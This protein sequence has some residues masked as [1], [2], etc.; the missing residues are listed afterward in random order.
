VDIGRLRL[1]ANLPPGLQGLAGAIRRD[2]GLYNVLS[3]AGFVQF[4]K[5]RDMDYDPVCFDLGTRLSDGDC[6]IVKFD[7]EE[8]LCNQRLVE[9]AELAP[10]F[11]QLIDI[12]IEDANRERAIEALRGAEL[13]KAAGHLRELGRDALSVL[14]AAFGRE[15]DVALRRR[16]VHTAWQGG[17]FE[18]IPFLAVALNDN[19]PTVWKEA[20]DGL[21]ALGAPDAEPLLLSAKEHAEDQ[22]QQYR[23][24]P[25]RNVV[26]AYADQVI[27]SCADKVIWI[28]KSL[29]QL[30]DR[31]SP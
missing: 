13:E 28:D 14:V 12:V 15:P 8:I 23:R 2:Q 3:P 21:M 10:D 27:E 31:K 9:V 19:E 24:L 5:G 1:L 18:A 29:P 30:R 4:G 6:R 26:G 7:H 25:F 22:Q 17:S 20:L 11:R 16:F